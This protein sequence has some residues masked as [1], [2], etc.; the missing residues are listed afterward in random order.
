MEWGERVRGDSRRGL[1]G[2]VSG[3]FEGE[4]E[5]RTVYYDPALWVSF[6]QLVA[7]CLRELVGW[8]GGLSCDFA[9][10]FGVDV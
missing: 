9:L 1:G 7:D 3:V 4:R 6:Q 8:A 5:E 2:L 10:V